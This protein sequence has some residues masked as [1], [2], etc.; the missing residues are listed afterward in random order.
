[1]LIKLYFEGICIRLKS[2]S[3]KEHLN[4]TRAETHSVGVFFI[5]DNT[6]RQLWLRSANLFHFNS[7]SQ[8]VYHLKCIP[9]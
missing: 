4:D 1:M 2:E 8:T 7:T 3:T 6:S 5:D 9:P